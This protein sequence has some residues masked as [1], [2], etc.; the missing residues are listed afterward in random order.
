MG[1]GFAAL[2]YQTIR[3]FCL[4]PSVPKAMTVAAAAAI[5]DPG[6]A[7]FISLT[8][9][10]WLCDHPLRQPSSVYSYGLARGPAG[11]RVLIGLP[12]AAT[13]PCP[14][15]AGQQF[16]GRLERRE[17]GDPLPSGVYWD[18][19]ANEHRDGPMWIV[20]T[21]WSP[22]GGVSMVL[23]VLFFGLMSLFGTAMFFGLLRQL[24]GDLRGLRVPRRPRLKGVLFRL[25][26]STGAS[27]LGLFGIS[28]GV[29][30]VV[31]FGWLFFLTVIPNWLGVVV[32]VL[33]G[34]WVLATFGIF[35]E[36]WKRRAS[37]L[38]LGPT[39][40]EI[41]G[42][43]LHGIGHR[44]DDAELAG[45]LC[46]LEF[47]APAADDILPEDT[48]TLYIQGEVA[49]MS[50]D[51]A[52]NLSLQAICDT[53][54]GA[55]AIAAP[56]A[57]PAG[58]PRRLAVVHCRGCGAAVPPREASAC[59]YCAH[60]LALPEPVRQQLRAQASRN[61]DRADS[62]RLLRRLL[63]QPSAW[64]VNALTVLLLPP[65]LLSWPVAGAVFDEFYQGRHLLRPHHGL[66]L[67]AAALSG[68]LAL[69]FLLRAQIAIRAAVRIIATHFAARPPAHRGAAPEC[70][71]CGAPLAEEPGQ[72]LVLCFYCGAENVTGLNLIPIAAEQAVQA[73]ELRL[74]L[75]ERLRIRRR[76]RWRSLVALLLLL[77][78]ALS[79]WPV[80]GVLRRG[81]PVPVTER[82]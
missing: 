9:A 1:L 79:L 45:G 70:R 25:P 64:R 20:W 28:I 4:A 51:P 80:R 26:L 29:V 6:P 57:V 30:Q 22:S 82:R 31:V 18:D 44:F 12:G 46:R 16:S 7:A 72:L 11:Q 53:L 36:G 74:A 52:E 17:P 54:Q 61:R 73:G 19:L 35:I 41:R 69:Q 39:G 27:A 75:V 33:A 10:T 78:C 65:L 71:L 32:G 38:L 77:T 21:D 60:P 14:P 42:G 24:L 63:R 68:N 58:V 3:D 5:P 48:A 67:A 40:C 34:L 62:E 43:P 2:V 56:D 59:P 50:Q 49:A 37:D 66:A 55:V 76:W 15:R 8:D 47:Q 81:A 13:A 23:K